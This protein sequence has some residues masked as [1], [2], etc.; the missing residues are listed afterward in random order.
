MKE[1]LF[2]V[3]P[4]GVE[5]YRPIPENKRYESVLNARR[6]RAANFMAEMIMKY[7]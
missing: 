7:G 3:T 6:T 4:E 2:A 5:L 1:E